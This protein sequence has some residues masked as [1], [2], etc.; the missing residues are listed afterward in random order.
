MVDIIAAFYDALTSVR[1]GRTAEI[2]SFFFFVF[3][4]PNHCPSRPGLTLDLTFVYVTPL[5]PMPVSPLP[6]RPS[7][8]S[9]QGSS[10]VIAPYADP[11]QKRC[12]QTRRSR[13][14]RRCNVTWLCDVQMI[15]LHFLQVLQVYSTS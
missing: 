8:A 7:S 14:V 9:A 11:A 6:P 15:L 2:V 13:I 5:A 4:N 10:R 1:I 12:F 3:L